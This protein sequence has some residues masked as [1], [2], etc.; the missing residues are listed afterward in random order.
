MR[1]KVIACNSLSREVYY[2]AALSP[3]TV[4]VELLDRSL[5]E[6]PARLHEALQAAIDATDSARYDTIVLGLALCSNATV[7]LV[8][9]A[10]PV[11]LP[12]AHDCIT[13]MLGSRQRYNS[14]FRNNPG[15]YYY[16]IGWIERAGMDKERITTEGKEAREK[17]YREYVEKYGEDNARYLMEVLHSWHK[18]YNLAAFITSPVP[19]LKALEGPAKDKVRELADEHGWAYEEAEGDLSLFR[20][21][22]FGDWNEDE[23]LV[24]PP[25]QRTV[26]SYDE[27]VIRCS[28]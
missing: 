18:N 23:F 9:P 17:I 7:D 26:P 16:T 22:L 25:G 4:D 21:L 5:H 2:T 12:R 6:E 28:V 1:L 3:H 13:L 10:I 24:I 20:K 8:A 19:Q 27:L 11:V 14:S 15:T